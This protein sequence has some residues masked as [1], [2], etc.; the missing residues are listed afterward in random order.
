MCTAPHL[1]FQHSNSHSN[2]SFLPE[3][4]SRLVKLVQE[5]HQQA[6]SADIQKLHPWQDNLQQQKGP[7]VIPLAQI[8]HLVQP[9]PEVAQEH[10]C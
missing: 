9:L 10:I 2:D 6:S 8:I 7:V 1:A 4:K 5:H 3:N